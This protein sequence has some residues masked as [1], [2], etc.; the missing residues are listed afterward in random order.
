MLKWFLGLA[1]GNPLIP[2][3]VASG[4]F[5]SGFGLG[6]TAAWKWQGV[7]LEALGV[8]M[9][10]LRLEYKEFKDATEL[11]GREAEK[12]RVLKEAEDKRNNQKVQDEYQRTLAKF[13]ADNKRL[14]DAR[15]GPSGSF[16]STPSPTATR[17]DLICFDR[18]QFDAALRG[19]VDEVAGIVE[20]GGACVIDLDSA[21]SWAKLA[22]PPP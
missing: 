13:A 18:G 10:A 5:L 7:K 15:A 20:E 2:V 19:F 1:V 22:Y 6:G 4:I 3:F 9:D 8:K 16:V 21:K 11:L 12:D 17:P 14:R